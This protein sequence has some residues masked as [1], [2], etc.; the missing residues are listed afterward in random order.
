[1]KVMKIIVLCVV[2]VGIQIF[3]V[4]MAARDKAIASLG[5]YTE[6]EFYSNDGPRDFVDYAKYVFET[7]DVS[8]NSYFSTLDE[9]G[10][11]T[12]NEYLDN[13]ENRIAMTRPDTDVV[14]FYDFDRNL[15]DTEDYFYIY[16]RE[17]K[18]RGSSTYGKFDFYNIY[19][20]DMQTNILYYFHNDT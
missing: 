16:S 10:I 19:F 1:M 8:D 18:P 20:L 4:Y 5:R 12:L 6:K 2:V 7:V 15:I 11:A 14:Q 3:G 9:E 17:E 13:F